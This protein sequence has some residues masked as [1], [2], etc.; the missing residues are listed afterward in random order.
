M[1]TIHVECLTSCIT[2]ARHLS[3]SVTKSFMDGHHMKGMHD[4]VRPS[5][6]SIDSLVGGVD[7]VTLV[8]TPI[9]HD[10]HPVAIQ[11]M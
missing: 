2:D 10:I 6:V 5:H 1:V 9:F 11:L 7:S 4:G 3:R 8:F